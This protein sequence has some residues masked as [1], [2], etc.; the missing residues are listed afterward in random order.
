MTALLWFK[1]IHVISMATWFAGLLYLGRLFVYHVEAEEKKQ[2][3]KQ[4][5]QAQF[6]IMERRLYYGIAWPGL[7]MTVG[8]GF[9]LMV[10]TQAYLEGWFHI[11]LTL[12]IALILYHF[13]AGSLRKKLLTRQNTWSLF[14][15]RLFNE[16]ATVFLISIVLLVYLKD[17]FSQVTGILTLTGIII[18]ILGG[19]YL[20]KIM[21]EKRNIAQKN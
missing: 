5:L 17:F 20:S 14:R 18:G 11:K 19:T 8:F 3:E 10:L 7:A 12:V 9:T 4:I 15:F 6:E 13:K 1:A 16:I 2:D 21:R